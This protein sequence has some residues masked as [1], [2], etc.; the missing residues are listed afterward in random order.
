MIEFHN[1][2]KRFEGGYEALSNVS[3]KLDEG[4]MAFIT[5]VLTGGERPPITAKMPRTNTL[6]QGPQSEDDAISQDDADSLFDFSDNNIVPLK[7]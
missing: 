3:L 2:T 5:G 1:V 6:L 4:H 7:S